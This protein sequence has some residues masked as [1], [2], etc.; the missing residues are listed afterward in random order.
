M[1]ESLCKTVARLKDMRARAVK[2]PLD[3]RASGTWSHDLH[4]AA[5][6]LLE[7]LGEIRPGDGHILLMAMSAFITTD[8]AKIIEVLRR[9]QSIAAKMEARECSRKD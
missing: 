6:A 9:Y 5:P 7:V 4:E 2:D 3:V 8:D 1:T